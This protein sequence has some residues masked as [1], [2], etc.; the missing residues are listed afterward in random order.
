MR[1]FI[2]VAI[3]V[4]VGVMFI[5]GLVSV[6]VMRVFA[7]DVVHGF[8]LS[9]TFAAPAPHLLRDGTLGRVA[10]SCAVLGIWCS[11]LGL[12]SGRQIALF[13]RQVGHVCGVSLS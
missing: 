9:E 2:F 12:F 11:L 13:V 10:A 6:V 5:M 1:F 3:H 8:P 4:I 7:L